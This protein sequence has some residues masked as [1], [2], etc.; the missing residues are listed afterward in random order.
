MFRVPSDQ[1]QELVITRD[2]AAAQIDKADR[3]KLQN[4]V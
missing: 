4:A 1:T 2:R 3:L